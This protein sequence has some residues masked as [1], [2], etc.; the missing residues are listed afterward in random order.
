MNKLALKLALI[1]ALSCAGSFAAGYLSAKHNAEIPECGL[2]TNKPGELC[3]SYQETCTTDSECEDEIV[4]D[5]ETS[6]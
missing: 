1:T 2:S 4:V 3:Y 6:A 5:G